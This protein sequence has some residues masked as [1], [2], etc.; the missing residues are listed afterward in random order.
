MD[1]GAR[2]A[3]DAKAMNVKGTPVPDTKVRLAW[4]EQ[5][6]T[7]SGSAV[8]NDLSE[9]GGLLDRFREADGLVYNGE[10]DYDL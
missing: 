2:P 10:G 1:F 4:F 9:G 3:F 5:S 8:E 6:S 7:E